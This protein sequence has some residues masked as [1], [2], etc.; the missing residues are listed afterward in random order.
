MEAFLREEELLRT[1]MLKQV[2][3]ELSGGGKDIGMSH[4]RDVEALFISREEES[5]CCLME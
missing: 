5:S 1:H 3:K 2:L 4:I